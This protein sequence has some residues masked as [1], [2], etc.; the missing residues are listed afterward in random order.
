MKLDHPVNLKEM[1]ARTYASCNS[2]SEDI[3]NERLKC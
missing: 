3:V 1:Y 2:R